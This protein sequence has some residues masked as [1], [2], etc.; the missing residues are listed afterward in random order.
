MKAK[1]QSP[2]ITSYP[3]EIDTSPEIDQDN[4]N[5]FKELI[6]LLHWAIEIVRSNINILVSLLSRQIYMLQRGHLDQSFNIFAYL[7]YHP[8]YNLVMGYER[9]LLGN[10]FKSYFKSNAEWFEFYNYTNEEIPFNDPNT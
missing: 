5:D 10:F 3:P 9:I 4:T 1:K 7:K 8:N 6:G 2:F